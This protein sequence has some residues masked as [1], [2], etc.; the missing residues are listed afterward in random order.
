VLAELEE[1]DILAGGERAAPRGTLALTAPSISANWCWDR[2]SMPSWTLTR[3]VRARSCCSTGVNL[4]D[5]GFDARAPHRRAGRLVD[6]RE[7]RSARCAGW[8]WPRPAYLKQHPRIEEPADLAKHQIISMAH[9]PNS[10]SF[11]ST[12]GAA[13]PRTVQFTP[14]S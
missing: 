2:S 6:G 12:P 11:P 7:T 9:I 10:W 1:A 4:I 14:G 13:V 3:R 8:W 5:E